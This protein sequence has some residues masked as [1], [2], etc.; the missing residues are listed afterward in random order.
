MS[1][2]DTCIE[3]VR[4]AARTNDRT[5]GVDAEEFRKAEALRC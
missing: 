1:V 4:I 3:W 5:L 2:F